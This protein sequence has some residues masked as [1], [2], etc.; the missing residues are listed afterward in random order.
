LVGATCVGV[1]W[2]LE[3]VLDGGKDWM[4]GERQYVPVVGAVASGGC[5]S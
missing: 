3:R 5:A 4:G 2:L 1:H